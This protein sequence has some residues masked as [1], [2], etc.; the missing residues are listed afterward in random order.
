M[1]TVERSITV[2][3]APDYLFDVLTHSP[4]ER[5]WMLGVTGSEHCTAGPLRQGSKMICKFGIGPFTTMK[6]DAV[7][8]EFEPG[9]RFVR[10]RVG[11]VMIMRGDFMVEPSDSGGARFIWKMNVGLCSWR[12]FSAMLD[13]FLAWWM[14][15]SMNI[16]MMKLKTLAESRKL[17]GTAT[18][19]TE[20]VPRYT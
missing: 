10:R 19:E 5:H 14:K 6:A 15:T 8:D 9:R 20:R 18:G 7:I 3:A 11:G 16:S 1:R 12:I 4:N 17:A 13:P 2:Q